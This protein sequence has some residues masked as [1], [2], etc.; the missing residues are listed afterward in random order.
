MEYGMERQ[1]VKKNLMET[2]LDLFSLSTALHA[3]KEEVVGHETY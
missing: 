1:T 2:R 3:Q